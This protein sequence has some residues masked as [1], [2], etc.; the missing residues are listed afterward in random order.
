MKRIEILSIAL[1][2]AACCPQKPADPPLNG[3]PTRWYPAE[4]EWPEHAQRLEEGV[5]RRYSTCTTYRDRGFV[6]STI[7][8]SHGLDFFDTIF[9][10][11]VGLR[12]R[13]LDERRRPRL[14][15]WQRGTE[16]REWHLGNVT[17]HP[18]LRDAAAA[19]RGTT[20]NMSE[21]ALLMLTG[22]PWL[23]SERA[24][25]GPWRAMPGVVSPACGRCWML[26][27]G[28]EAH[29]RQFALGV[30][31]E[32]FALR[33]LRSLTRGPEVSPGVYREYEAFVAFE[34]EFDVPHA[35]LIEE[36]EVQPW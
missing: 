26:T 35:P 32:A 13:L 9:V 17:T 1:M 18:T 19:A 4:P 33:R 12:F 11:S 2:L 21:T 36:L 8:V 23:K 34:P 29:G 28:S 7:S 24:D 16:V 5:K 25:L 20:H 3:A 31:E 22:E 6:V 30:D 27:A 14:I 10:R 15:I